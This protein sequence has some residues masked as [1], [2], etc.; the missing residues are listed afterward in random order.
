MRIIGIYRTYSINN[1]VI[2]DNSLTK[3]GGTLPPIQP[4]RPDG[5]ID[6][7]SRAEHVR[8]E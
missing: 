3:I 2:C 4:P 5:K 8:A 6:P 1:L 7:Y